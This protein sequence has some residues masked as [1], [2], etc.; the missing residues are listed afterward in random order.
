MWLVIFK[1]VKSVQLLTV[2]ETQSSDYEA[3][4]LFQCNEKGTDRHVKFVSYYETEGH[5]VINF[6]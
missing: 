3:K 5:R 6:F 2:Y 4:C 1:S